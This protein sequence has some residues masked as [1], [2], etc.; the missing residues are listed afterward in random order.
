MLNHA[1]SLPADGIGF[2]EDSINSRSKTLGIP[3][4]FALVEKQLGGRISLES[5][6]GTIFRLTFRFKEKAD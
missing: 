5:K 1:H 4:V 2:P 6:E 3:L